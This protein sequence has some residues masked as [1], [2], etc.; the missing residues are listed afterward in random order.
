MATLKSRGPVAQHARRTACRCGRGCSGRSARSTGSGATAPLSN[1]PGRVPRARA[2]LDAGWASPAAAAAGLRP[3]HAAAV[4]RAAR[5]RGAPP[6]QGTVTC[7]PTR[8]PASP[9]RRSARAVELLE[10]GRLAVRLESGG[11]CGRPRSPR[12]CSTARRKARSLAAPAA[13][14]PAAARRSSAASRPACSRC[15]TEHLALLPDDPRVRDVAAPARLVDELLV[16]AI[17]DGALRCAR[18]PGWP[19]G[20]S[21][22][23]AT[24][25]RRPRS[26][27]RR[28]S[29]CCADPGRR[30]GR[31]RR[32]VLRHGRLVRLRGRALRRVDARSART[33]CSPPCAPPTTPSSPPP[34]CPAGS[35]SPTAPSAR[36]AA[37]SSW[38]WRPWPTGA[39]RG[40]PADE[41]GST[42]RGG[43]GASASVVRSGRAKNRRRGQRVMVK[44]DPPWP[45]C[46]RPGPGRLCRR[47][48]RAH[49]GGAVG[50]PAPRR[51]G[52]NR[53]WVMVVSA[54]E[55]RQGVIFSA[56]HGWS[57]VRSRGPALPWATSVLTRARVHAGEGDQVLARVHDARERHRDAEDPRQR[58]GGGA[59]GQ[60]LVMCEHTAIRT[61]GHGMRQTG[62][63]D[64][65]RRVGP[66]R[67]GQD[68]SQR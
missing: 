53:P 23:T 46:T 13:P 33:G 7:S 29:P 4:V 36:P 40:M 10:R 60:G 52:V 17:D 9:S 68:G 65:R 51:S 64:L 30:G 34:A 44:P 45:S 14:A 62:A 18:T 12:A 63:G 42:H 5:R 58:T 11:C 56:A 57:A 27:P 8:S 67:V 55:V 16:E 61:V 6:A 48:P 37:R 25:T 31:A 22:S 39:P 20:G 1:L 32:R 59:E 26:A 24:A 49:R 38:S 50:T 28:R 15:A 19:G 66:P 54:G 35:R 43:N 3:P 41:V 2:L 47:W 21:S